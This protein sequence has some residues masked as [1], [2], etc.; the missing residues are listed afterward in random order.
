[1]AKMILE[2]LKNH[3]EGLVQRAV[4]CERDEQKAEV[5][6]YTTQIT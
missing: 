1:M 5:A 4:I 6:A 2:F 3:S